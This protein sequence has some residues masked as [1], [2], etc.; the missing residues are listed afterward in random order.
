[1]K[2]KTLYNWA[3]GQPKTK[4]LCMD[5]FLRNFLFLYLFL[6][7]EIYSSNYNLYEANHQIILSKPGFPPRLQA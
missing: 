3:K 4:V 5:L 7:T 1:M 6:L 2:V